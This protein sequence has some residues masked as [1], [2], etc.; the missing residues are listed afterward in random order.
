MCVCVW[1]F[2][3]SSSDRVF[4]S[5]TVSGEMADDSHPSHHP[6]SSSPELSHAAGHVRQQEVTRVSASTSPGLLRPVPSPSASAVSPKRRRLDAIDAAH[7]SLVQSRPPGDQRVL[8]VI[9]LDEDTTSPTAAQSV[10]ATSREDCKYTDS[11]NYPSPSPINVD[12]AA[13]PHA[14]CHLDNENTAL[15]PVDRKPS[16]EDV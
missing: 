9:H 4:G 2:L 3:G 1:C 14:N 5:D 12:E 11:P 8:P 10:P 16:T 15:P 6:W 7:Q 13:G